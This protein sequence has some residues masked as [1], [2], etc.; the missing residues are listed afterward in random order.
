MISF[1]VISIFCSAWQQ[2]RLRVLFVDFPHDENIGFRGKI[3]ISNVNTNASAIAANPP[4]LPVN[5]NALSLTGIMT[6]P[7]ARGCPPL[8]AHWQFGSDV[9]VLSDSEEPEQ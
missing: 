9:T 3:A 2:L 7:R 8:F 1:M 6:S 4:I 5:L